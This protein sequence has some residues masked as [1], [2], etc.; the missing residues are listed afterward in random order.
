MKPST[1]FLGEMTNREV[2]AFLESHHTVI[3]PTGATEQHG[4]HGPLATD[5]LIPLE[6]ARR[7]APQIGAVVAPP[8]AYALSYPHV[9]FTGLVHIRIPTF[10][11][12]IEDL[13]VSFAASGFRR[14][15]YLNGHYDNTYAIAYA[16]ANAAERLPRG[17]QAFPVNYWDALT[18]EEVAEFSGLANGLHANLAETSAVMRINPDLVDLDN[19]NAEFPPF[20][21]FTVPT[22]P[23]HSAFFFSNPGSVHWATKSGTWGDAR[24]SNPEAGE[25]YLQAGV[26]ST[27]AIIDN[28]ARTFAAMPPR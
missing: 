20:P 16:C 27:L 17:T 26:R 7:M 21:E 19:A 8:I 22:G 11:A 6:V 2:E 13:C 12:M 28:I 14:I 10:M 25:R 5:V 15:I 24:K 23:V 4:P 9:G 1:V 18:S 3:I